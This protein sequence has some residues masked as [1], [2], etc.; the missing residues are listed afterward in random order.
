M[1]L[2]SGLLLLHNLGLL[3]WYAGSTK[4][5]VHKAEAQRALLADQ[6]AQG[7]AEY[8]E[9]RRRLLI[10]QK[11]SRNL[12]IL[13]GRLAKMHDVF[14]R[15]PGTLTSDFFVNLLASARNGSRRLMPLTRSRDAAVRRA[16]PRWTASRV[17]LVFGSSSELRARAEVRA[18]DD[19]KDKFGGAA[20]RVDVPSV[21]PC[22]LRLPLGSASV[23]AS[24]GQQKR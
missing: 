11:L 18:C 23:H 16:T 22:A 7:Y 10:A 19:A 12:I 13:Y 24:Q 21:R 17:D 2:L 3:W 6:V 15:R 4:Q 20:R 1:Y 9:S 5:L 8:T 14:T